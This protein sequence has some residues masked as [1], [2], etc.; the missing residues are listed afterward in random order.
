MII[1]ALLLLR[2]SVRCWTICGWCGAGENWWWIARARTR[3]VLVFA[4]SAECEYI[5]TSR[6]R[7]SHT[8][9][10]VIYWP[11]E[12]FVHEH[13]LPVVY[14]RAMTSLR[15]N[16]HPSLY[17]VYLCTHERYVHT[18]LDLGVFGLFMQIG[19]RQQRFGQHSDDATMPKNTGHWSHA[20]CLCFRVIYDKSPLPPPSLLD[21]ARSVRLE[22]SVCVFVCINRLDL[23]TVFVHVWPVRHVFIPLLVFFRVFVCVV[24]RLFRSTRRTWPRSQSLWAQTTSRQAANTQQHDQQSLLSSACCVYNSNEIINIDSSPTF[25]NVLHTHVYWVSRV[26][27]AHSI[28]SCPCV[29]GDFAGDWFGKQ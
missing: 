18:P 1:E 24:R 4:S 17:V 12:R 19:R 5:C 16:Y 13:R 27:C 3:Q 8:L 26:R 9:A 2:L 29:P 7:I 10:S 21:V 11:L 15:T 14:S 6:P 25:A 23:K 20:L 22:F 28:N